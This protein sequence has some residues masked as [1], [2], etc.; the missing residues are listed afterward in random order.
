MFV[1]LEN[2]V[3]KNGFRMVDWCSLIRICFAPQNAKMVRKG[4]RTV[5]LVT[6]H[7]DARA[8]V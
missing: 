1:R 5:W 4:K 3:P 6:M 8:A 7:S 2:L